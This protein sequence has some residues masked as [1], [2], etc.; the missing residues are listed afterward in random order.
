MVYDIIEEVPDELLDEREIFWIKELN[1][2]APNGY[3]LMT[4]GGVNREFSQVTKDKMSMIQRDRVINKNGYEGNIREVDFGFY[5]RVKINGKEKF[6]SD[7]VCRTREEAEKVLKEY[8]RDPENF[9]KPDGSG[10]RVAK[11]HVSLDSNSKKWQ[12]YD[13]EQKY[14]CRCETKEEAEKV[15]KEYTRDPENFVKPGKTKRKN[16]TG[17]IRF[18]TRSNKWMARIGEKYLGVYETKEEAEKILEEYTRDP[19]NFVKPGKMRRK[20]GTGGIRFDT[21]LNKWVARGT[22]GKYLGVHETKEEA[23]SVLEKYN[24]TRGKAVST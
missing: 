22:G 3:N 10:K 4:G 1:C 18:D 9:V 7:G 8:T 13:K 5:P 16:G 19:E 17:G 11:G 12:V 14:L 24:I 23:E 20:K 6:L 21:R 15:L 2:L